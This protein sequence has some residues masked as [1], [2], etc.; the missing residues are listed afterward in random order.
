MFWSRR[1]LQGLSKLAERRL[2]VL[3]P[4]HSTS[5]ATVITHVNGK[6]ISVQFKAGSPNMSGPLRWCTHVGH[7][8][9]HDGA[10]DCIVFSLFGC[11]GSGTQHLILPACDF[12]KKHDDDN[13]CYF[14]V[15]NWIHTPIAVMYQTS[16]G[17]QLQQLR[18]VK[19]TPWFEDLCEHL[20]KDPPALASF[21]R[22][23]EAWKEQEYEQLWSN[24]YVDLELWVQA[25]D[26]LHVNRHKYCGYMW[27]H[28]CFGKQPN[29][30][31]AKQIAVWDQRLATMQ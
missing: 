23:R 5:D 19:P 7:K 16:Q 20:G 3:H 29:T 28:Y 22:Q 21:S 15:P 1:I 13:E 27:E 26:R 4:E 17:Q 10:I 31:V 24:Y 18:E 2:V 30:A 12:V 11:P 14:T 25:A 9:Y 8:Q 6:A